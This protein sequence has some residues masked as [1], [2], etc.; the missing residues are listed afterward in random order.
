MKETIDPGH[1]VQ[2]LKR[3]ANKFFENAA[4][5]MAKRKQ[6]GRKTIKACME[7]FSVLITKIITWFKFLIFNVDSKDKKEQMWINTAEHVLGNHKE[8]THPADLKKYRGRGRPR[9][10]KQNGTEFWE[11]DAGKKESNLKNILVD[12][13]KKTVKLV[14]KTGKKRT[15]DN[16]SLNASMRIY[17]PKNKVF[18]VSN[19]A[20][21]AIAVGKKNDPLFETHL[22]EKVC[23]NAISPA[24]LEEI[25]KDEILKHQN[26]EHKKTR[27]EMDKKN[28]KRIK[29]RDRCKEPP[30]DYN[31][32]K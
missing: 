3:N 2:Q 18:S 31:E 22:I 30:G 26:N 21:V 14:R 19:E 25:R 16:E 29:E 13:L 7:L 20:R 32:K 6:P 17:A 9:K 5:E 11:W 8:C 28:L 10:Q 27:K 12:F 24:A 1:G 23:P 4:R 15:Q